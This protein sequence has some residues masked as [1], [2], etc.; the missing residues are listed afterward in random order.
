MKRRVLKQ[1]EVFADRE[2]LGVQFGGVALF[3]PSSTANLDDRVLRRAHVFGQR[4]DALVFN[5]GEPRHDRVGQTRPTDRDLPKNGRVII[6][7]A[8]HGLCRSAAAERAGF[9]A[10]SSDHFSLALGRS[11]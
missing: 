2:L 1:T 11:R 9:D 4:H 7:A 5:G 3:A 10:V 8:N 6:G